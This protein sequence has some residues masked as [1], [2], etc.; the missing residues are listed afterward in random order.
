MIRAGLLC[1]AALRSCT[2]LFRTYLH[3]TQM[4]DHASADSMH[5]SHPSSSLVTCPVRGPCMVI[6]PVPAETRIVLTTLRAV[7][8]QQHQLRAQV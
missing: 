7:L 1:A 8:P 2:A 5:A 4:V 3:R 6:R